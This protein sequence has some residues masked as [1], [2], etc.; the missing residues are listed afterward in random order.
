M[1]RKWSVPSRR[2]CQ[3]KKSIIRQAVQTKDNTPNKIRQRN[4]ERHNS[5][6]NTFK[7]CIKCRKK[8]NQLQPVQKCPVLFI[9]NLYSRSP[10]NAL[11]LKIYMCSS[12]LQCVLYSVPL[13]V[14]TI[15]QLVRYTQIEMR[16]THGNR[17]SREAWY[18]IGKYCLIKTLILI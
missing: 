3:K 15:T 11:H 6:Y 18:I 9:I 17:C 5:M 8:G 12:I 2:K 16:V 1:V 14:A 7:I 10:I 13:I 4:N